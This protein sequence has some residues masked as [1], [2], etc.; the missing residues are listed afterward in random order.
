MHKAKLITSWR[1]I[2]VTVVVLKWSD[3]HIASLVVNLLTE[4][5]M[6]GPL[7][8]QLSPFQLQRNR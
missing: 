6:T 3:N 8:L 5:P 4:F 1:Q 2:Y 7:K